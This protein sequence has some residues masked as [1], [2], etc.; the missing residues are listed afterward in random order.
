MDKRTWAEIDLNAVEHNIREIRRITN[1]SSK[2]MAVVKADAY[3]HGVLNVANVLLKNGADM[4]GVA[5]MDEAIELRVNGFSE[6]ILILGYCEQS[7]LKDGVYYG[8]TMT[9]CSYEFA[10]QISD[11][12][13]KAGKTAKIHIKID[14]GMSRI[15]FYYQ[16]HDGSIEEIKRI[17]GLPNLLVEG[18]FTHFATSDEADKSYTNRQ[19]ELFC[20]ICDRLAKEGYP[21][22]VRHCSNSGAIIDCPQMHLDMVRAGIILY[23]YYPSDEVDKDKLSLIPAM[24]LK[25]TVVQVK[26]VGKGAGISY[27]KTVVTERPMR[28]ATIPIGYADG[29]P[30]SLSNKG[31]VEINGHMAQIIGRVCMDQ[32]MIDVSD[33]PEVKRGDQ[34][35]LFGKG[36]VSADTIAKIRGTIHYE[37]LCDVKRRVPRIYFKDGKIIEEINYICNVHDETWRGKNSLR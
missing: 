37:V 18:I 15:G 7:R 21:I 29:Y 28:I 20:E 34:V 13:V 25:S 24:T 16:E 27:G 6:D 8:I 3:G 23:G 35:T 17:F 14:T 33:L 5:D 1:E 9:V 10:K 12:A 31:L 22:A 2:I 36:Q 26:E 30:R 11:T 4:L 32:C 19:F